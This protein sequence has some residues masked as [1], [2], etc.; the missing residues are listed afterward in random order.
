VKS[1]ILCICSSNE[2][3]KK[4]VENFLGNCK[5]GIFRGT[6]VSIKMDIGKQDS[7]CVR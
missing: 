6:E 1:K 4:C 5:I 7:E 2:G 3:S